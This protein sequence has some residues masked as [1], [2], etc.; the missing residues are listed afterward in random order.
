M[1]SNQAKSLNQLAKHV[2]VI[3]TT[4]LRCISYLA[5]SLPRKIKMTQA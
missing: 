2:E 3:F 5:M 4:Q 1:K